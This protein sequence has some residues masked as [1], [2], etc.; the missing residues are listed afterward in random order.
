[1]LGVDE[2]PAPVVVRFVSDLLKVGLQTWDQYGAR[3]QTRREH[4]VELQDVYGYQ[5]FT[6]EHRQQAIDR[7]VE[8]AWLTD[9]S[10]I[11]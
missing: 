6:L 1:M 10:V 8:V 11:R 9:K 4:L 2:E 5:V 7:L 3:G